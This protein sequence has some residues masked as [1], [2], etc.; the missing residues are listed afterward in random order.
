MRKL[1]SANFFRLKKDKLFFLTLAAVFIIAF[2]NIQSCAGSAADS[3]SNGFESSLD[4]YFFALAPYMGAIYAIFISLFL[5]TEY[6]D[7]TIRNKL[8]VGHTRTH[9]YFANYFC[10]LF[11]CLLFAAAWL[12]GSAPGLFLIG[13]FQMGTSGFLSYLLVI[14]GFTLTFCALFTAL[15]MLSSNKAFSVVFSLL[16]WLG[17]ILA[18]SG[19]NDRLDE[20]AMLGGRAFIDGKFVTIEPT[21]NPLYL[22]GTVR[23]VCEYLRDALPSGQ[24]ILMSDASI[25]HPTRQFL[26]SLLLTAALLAAGMAAFHRKNIK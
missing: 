4:K 7:G 24:A 8:S 18:A 13:S 20:V 16:L 1:L 11:S 26:L 3:L 23:T 15:G 21:P 2:L 12:A 6:S 22:K 19:L 14:I 9:I 17:L 25:V 5:G 10:C